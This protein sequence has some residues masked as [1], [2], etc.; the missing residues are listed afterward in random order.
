MKDRIRYC[1]TVVCVIVLF[2][3]LSSFASRTLEFDHTKLV[4]VSWCLYALAGYVGCKRFDFLS[5]I[6]VGLIAGFSDSTV[7]WA[8]SSAIGPYVP[9]TEPR[10]TLPLIS[11]VVISVSIMGAFFGLIGS[12]VCHITRGS[13][14]SADA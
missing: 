12:L 6:A 7:G 14:R 10:Y 13:G 1:L 11:V 2:D 9:S 5:G 4:W 8:L 3:V